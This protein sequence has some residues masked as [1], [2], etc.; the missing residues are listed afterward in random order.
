MSVVRRSGCSQ[1]KWIRTNHSLS[2]GALHVVEELQPLAEHIKLFVRQRFANEAVRQVV[3]K[4]SQDPV[5]V[6]MKR[7]A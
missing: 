3:L 2:V 1:S 6:A 5:A 7:V 4:T